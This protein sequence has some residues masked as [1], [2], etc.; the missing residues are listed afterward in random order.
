MANAQPAQPAQARPWD[1]NFKHT[2]RERWICLYPAYINSRK[3][4]NEGRKLPKD[5]C[6]DNPQ[7]LEIRDVL[8]PCGLLIGIENKVY[9]R[10]LDH[11]DLK[12]RGRVRVQIKGENGEP[13]MEKFPDRKAV[14]KYVC[15]MIPKLKTRQ[16]SGAST[17]SQAQPTQSS[18]SQ[19][20][21]GRKG[22]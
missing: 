13:M 6:V 11:R 7:T 18:K 5:M 8:G 22:K 14:L 16:S 4:V 12:T 17:Q 10:E 20:K 3:T 9:P 19:K 21:K 2:D 1:P 15:E